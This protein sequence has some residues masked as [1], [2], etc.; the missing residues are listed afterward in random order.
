MKSNGAG[1][2]IS[3]LAISKFGNT[4]TESLVSKED[5]GFNHQNYQKSRYNKTNTRTDTK[6]LKQTYSRDNSLSSGH[7]GIFSKKQSV[8][9]KD[10]SNSRSTM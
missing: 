6:S 9:R 10:N 1:S 3:H 5:L 8:N 4:N 2:E 7:S